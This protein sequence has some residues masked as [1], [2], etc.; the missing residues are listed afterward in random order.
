MDTAIA[1]SIPS[2]A[3]IWQKIDP[4]QQRIIAALL[5]ECDE[6]ERRRTKSRIKPVNFP[7]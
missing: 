5:K 3:N 7:A 2:N 1:M 6:S 4:I